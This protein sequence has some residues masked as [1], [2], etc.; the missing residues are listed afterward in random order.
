MKMLKKILMW[1][2]IAFLI[3]A[4]FKHP[5]QAGGYAQDAWNFV[6]Q[7][8]KSLFSFFNSILNKH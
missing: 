5:T 8:F 1:T 2:L 4:V 6:V 7:L 3:Y